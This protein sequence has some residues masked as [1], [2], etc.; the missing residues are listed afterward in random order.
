MTVIKHY[1]NVGNVGTAYDTSSHTSFIS[2]SQHG[3]D[4]VF[5]DAHVFV[6]HTIVCMY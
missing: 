2:N 3:P 5:M 1:T 6:Y 4:E